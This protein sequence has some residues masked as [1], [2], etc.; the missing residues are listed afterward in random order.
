MLFVFIL[1]ILEIK[2]SVKSFEF[3]KTIIKS[4]VSEVR[5]ETLKFDIPKYKIL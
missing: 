4:E 2:N 1:I 3:L 5:E